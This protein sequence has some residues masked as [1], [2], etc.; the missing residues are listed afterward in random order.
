MPLTTPSL[1]KRAYDTRL[2][3][4]GSATD[5]MLQ[6]MIANYL[7]APAPQAVFVAPI[8]LQ[9]K[10]VNLLCVQSESESFADD[11][12][13]KLTQLVQYSAAAYIRLIVNKKPEAK[14]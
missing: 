12:I 2:P 8:C 13:E 1:L 5:D 10:V 9:E 4:H 6:Q 11:A 14:D 3:A 7:Q